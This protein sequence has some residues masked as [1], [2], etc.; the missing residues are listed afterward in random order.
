MATVI[1]IDS[2]S[3]LEINIDINGVQIKQQWHR[4]GNKQLW[5]KHKPKKLTLNSFEGLREP[6]VLRPPVKKW[7]DHEVIEFQN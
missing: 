4:R 6:G 3:N 2:T 5:K 1:N 7:I